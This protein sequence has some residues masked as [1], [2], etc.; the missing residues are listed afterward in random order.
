MKVRKTELAT[1]FPPF[2]III[3]IETKD[4]ARALWA[5]FNYVPNTD[6][7]PEEMSEEVRRTIGGEF[8]CLGGEIAKGVTYSQFY[9]SKVK[10][11]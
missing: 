10:E 9:R 2:E 4:E 8:G 11:K 3:T 1:N 7:L 5:I 6:L